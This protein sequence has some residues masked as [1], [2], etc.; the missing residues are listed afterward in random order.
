MRNRL[1]LYRLPHTPRVWIAQDLPRVLAK[2]LIFAVLVAPRRR[3]VRYMLRGLVDGLRGRSGPC[4][5][6]AQ[7]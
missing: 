2:F 3:N 6:G 7:R 1:T 5:L 4:P